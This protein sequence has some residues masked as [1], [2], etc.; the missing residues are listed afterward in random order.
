MARAP[1]FYYQD[2]TAAIGNSM[3]TAIFGDPALRAQQQERQ[4]QLEERQAHARLYNTQADGQQGQNAASTSLPD[5]IAKLTQPPQPAP[6]LPSLDDPN[7]L[8]GAGPSAPQPSRED[9]FRAGL[10]P[11]VAALAQLQG[12]KVDTG[13]TIGTLASFLGGD[14]LARR[15]LVAQGHSPTADFAITPERADVI[16][17]NDAE[18]KQ[19]QAWGVANINHANDIP[20][21]NIRRKSA[22][23]V[24]TVNN[25]DDVPVAQIAAKSRLDV[26]GLKAS[27]PPPAFSAIQKVF[28]GATMNSG[29]RSPEHNREVGGVANST[30]LGDTPGVQGYDLDAQPGMTVEQAAAA[31]EQQNP[32]VRVVEAR[33]ERGRHGPNGKPLGGWHFALANVGDGGSA[34]AP[35][36]AKAPPVPKAVSKS[37]L[38]MID[39]ELD[40]YYTSR[41]LSLTGQARDVLRKEAIASF[42]K[43][44]NPVSAVVDTIEAR[45]ASFRAKRA[46]AQ[47][48]QPAPQARQQVVRVKSLEEAMALKP[49]TPYLTPDGKPYVR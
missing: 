38:D 12:D 17:A 26:A 13:Q 31:I 35:K 3:V 34:S 4:A 9:V 37:S 44:G 46:A 45:A 7:F 48:A 19:K 42:Q 8:D 39:D 2:P 20:V 15:G 22:F 23:D 41:G 6:Q 5:L 29:W 25:R 33:D 1:N 28:P 21:A 40:N 11:V 24:A 18:A 49:G 36:P 43:T 30:H 32:G 16:A 47:G 10:G 27:G 14:E